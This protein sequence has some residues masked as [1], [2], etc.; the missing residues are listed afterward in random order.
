M[1]LIDRKQLH[2]T[3]EIFIEYLSAM[4]QW[5]E[6]HVDYTDVQTDAVTKVVTLVTLPIKSWIHAIAWKGTGWNST[7]NPPTSLRLALGDEDLEDRWLN[8]LTIH[9]AGGGAG[10]AFEDG[11]G[12]TP[13]MPD[14]AATHDLTATFFAARENEGEDLTNLTAGTLDVRFLLSGMDL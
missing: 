13:W 12:L 1:T 11:I 7:W 10:A 14:S 9:S 4:P 8:D 6:F 2:K 5:Y 3:E